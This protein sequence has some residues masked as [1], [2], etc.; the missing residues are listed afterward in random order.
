MS[1]PCALADFYQLRKENVMVLKAHLETLLIRESETQATQERVDHCPHRVGTPRSKP[2]YRFL[3]ISVAEKV[4]TPLHLFSPTPGVWK[5]LSSERYWEAV[6]S[7]TNLC[8]S[9]GV[10]TQ[11]RILRSNRWKDRLGMENNRQETKGKI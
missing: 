1:T 8:A 7:G 10:R 5:K 11:N 3:I 2:I 9:L 6:S 4:N